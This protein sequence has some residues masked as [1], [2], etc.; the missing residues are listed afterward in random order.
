MQT[1]WENDGAVFS[2]LIEYVASEPHLVKPHWHDWHITR[3]TGGMNNILYRATNGEH[4]VAIKWV[5]RDDRDRAGREYAAMLAMQ[6]AGLSVAPTPILLEQERYAQ[7]VVVY[8]WL[9]GD[10]NGNLPTTDAEWRHVLQHFAL[11]HSITP[12]TITVPLKP[13]ALNANTV[14]E[15]RQL[16]RQHLAKLPGEAQPAELRELVGRFEASA[17][18]NWPEIPRGLCRVDTNLLNFIRQPEQWASVDWENGGWGDPT[19]DMAQL[20]THPVYMDVPLCRWEWVVTT[21]CDMRRQPAYAPRIWDYYSILMVWWVVR[22]ARCLY[23][24]P[25]K[26]DQR[27]VDMP[28]NWETDIRAKY[29]HYLTVAETLYA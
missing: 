29:T 9:H 1:Q 25:R 11:V 17:L 14:E 20:M 22:F 21:Y 15:G 10:V 13:G 5:I 18:P 3:M 26:L 23:E 12:D 8:Q 28:A 27:L 24:F 6:Q 16:V 19:F 7:P 2:P 4:D